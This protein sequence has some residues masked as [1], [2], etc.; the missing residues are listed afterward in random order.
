MKVKAIKD[1]F[2]LELNKAVKALDEFEVS[3]A[4]AKELSGSDNK[5]KQPLVEVIEATP[6]TPK[7]VAKAAPKKKV[8]DK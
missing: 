1:Y 8:E 6:T 5:A 7:K 3:E 4:R 2:D